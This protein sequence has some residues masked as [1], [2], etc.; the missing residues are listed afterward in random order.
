MVGHLGRQDSV[1]SLCV[2]V[3]VCAKV[4][5]PIMLKLRGSTFLH[6][7]TTSSVFGPAGGQLLQALDLHMYRALPTHRSS[8]PCDPPRGGRVFVW[9][10]G[11][12][13]APWLDP[14]PHPKKGSIDRTPKILPRPWGLGG[15][16]DPKIGKKRK[17]DF[18]NQCVEGVQKSYHL[19]YIG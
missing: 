16:L 3:C 1:L 18:W 11:V 2:C 6:P 13:R 8:W 19:P 10:G 5:I 7:T 12:D 9:L 14:P 15:D 17:W 4:S